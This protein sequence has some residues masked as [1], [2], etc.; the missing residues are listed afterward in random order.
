MIILPYPKPLKKNDKTG[1][2]RFPVKISVKRK[3]LLHQISAKAFCFVVAA[4][5]I[6]P[7]LSVLSPKRTPDKLPEQRMGLIRSRLELGMELHP[8]VKTIFRNLD[9]LDKRA[10]R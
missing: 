2:R 8:D 4:F 1:S 10:V 5:M 7:E 9:S 6:L 3:K